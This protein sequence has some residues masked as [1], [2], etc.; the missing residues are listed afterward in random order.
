M[1][2]GGSPALGGPFPTLIAL[3]GPGPGPGGPDIACGCCVLYATAA[4]YVTSRQAKGAA[5][6]ASVAGEIPGGCSVHASS[7]GLGAR[8]RAVG[9]WQVVVLQWFFGGVLNAQD[10]C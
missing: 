5:R 3:L 6:C 1:L 10:R 7:G 8:G 2:C 4:V 9:S